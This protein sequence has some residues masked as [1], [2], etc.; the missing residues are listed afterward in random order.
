MRRRV[1]KT[2]EIRKPELEALI[3][4]RMQQGQDVEDILMQAFRLT[5]SGRSDWRH[6]RGMAR[7]GA[8][9]L[10]QA[11]TKERAA[12]NLHDEARTQSPGM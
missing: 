5:S 12:E 6:M 7:A 8:D 10:T 2:I 3:L 4:D 9:S 1:A 11:L